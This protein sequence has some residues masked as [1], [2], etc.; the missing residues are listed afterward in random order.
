MSSYWWCPTCERE[1]DGRRVTHD[2]LCDACGFPVETVESEDSEMDLKDRV[3]SQWI[4]DIRAWLETQPGVT[5]GDGSPLD[6]ILRVMKHKDDQL[7]AAEAFV[8]KH[9]CGKCG[10]VRVTEQELC[11]CTEAAKGGRDATA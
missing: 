8:A 10:G 3:Y 7:A 2:E 6:G 9:K 1:I 4:R 5:E 11:K